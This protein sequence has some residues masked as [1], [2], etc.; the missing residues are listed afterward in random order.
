MMPVNWANQSRR[1]C[2]RCTGVT[3]CS[4]RNWGL[5]KDRISSKAR[6]KRAAVAGGYRARAASLTAITRRATSAKR[7][8]S[9]TPARLYLYETLL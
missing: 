2:R 1:M 9:T 3:G 5:R 7:L 4:R 8:T 6:Q